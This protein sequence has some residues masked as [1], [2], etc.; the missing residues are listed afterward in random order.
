MRRRQIGHRLHALR[1]RAA[2]DAGL[3]RFPI[4]TLQRE[5]QHGA[6]N[7]L[8]DAGVGPGHDQRLHDAA[9]AERRASASPRISASLRSA[10]METR[11]RDVPSGTVGGRMARTSKLA[12]WSARASFSVRSS[13][14]M[15]MGMIWLAVTWAG[16]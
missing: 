1:I 12:S 4:D 5:C 7:G 10:W 14:P 6:N 3:D 2:V 11:N 15:W 13:S 8:A 16:S 9:M